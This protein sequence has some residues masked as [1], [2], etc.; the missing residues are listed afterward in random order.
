MAFDLVGMLNCKR[1]SAEN[2]HGEPRPGIDP[3]A[4]V[5][6][7]EELDAIWVQLPAE[8]QASMALVLFDVVQGSEW[9][10]WLRE[11]LEQRLLL[12]TAQ[13]DK[14]I[15]V[16][17]IN[18][19]YLKRAGLSDDEIAQLG[20]RGIQMLADEIGDIFEV[21]H[22]FWFFVGMTAQRI[23]NEDL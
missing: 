22:S 21:D 13:Q 8:H 7:K 18:A 15:S 9:G 19:A 17:S 12:D 5:G 20:K 1:M 4:I 16:V 2:S 23:I 6:L 11:G 3:E 14:T 10:P